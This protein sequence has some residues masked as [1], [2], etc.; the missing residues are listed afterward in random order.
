MT[1]VTSRVELV[2]EL[3]FSSRFAVPWHQRLYDWSA[4]EVRELLEDIHGA[5]E[6]HSKCYFIGSIMLID[7][8]SEEVLTINDGQQRLVTLSMLVAALCRRFV[9]PPRNSQREGLA[10]RALF[11]RSGRQTSHLSE[12]SKYRPR[13]KPP[14]SDEAKYYHVI[15]GHD[16]G[17]NGQLTAAW[18]VIE[19]FGA[20]VTQVV[21][22]VTQDT[23]RALKR[24][25]SDE[26]TSQDE[27]AVALIEEALTGRGLLEG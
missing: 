5:M 9:A 10:L 1:Q 4:E 2:S 23:H 19:I 3:L 12:A 7:S 13:I 21:A 20:R 27:A 18:N 25:A 15:R 11:E 17:T 26:G 8:R 24:F 16:I 6:A 14:R 22:T